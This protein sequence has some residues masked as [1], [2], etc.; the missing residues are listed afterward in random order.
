MKNKL[1]AALIIFALFSYSCVGSQTAE[2]GAGA[3]KASWSQ[4]VYCQVDEL[5][6][7]AVAQSKED[8]K[9]LGGTKVSSCTT[10]K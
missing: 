4:A 2:S 5:Q 6:V 7:C 8:C 10:S 3:K 1:I 9:K